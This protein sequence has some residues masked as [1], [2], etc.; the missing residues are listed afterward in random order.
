MGYDW[1]F[2]ILSQGLALLV[3]AFVVVCFIVGIVHDHNMSKFV[4]ILCITVL[5]I[6]V[7]YVV[8]AFL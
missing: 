8:S 5:A 1:I 7:G 4:K 2:T 3:G 6:V